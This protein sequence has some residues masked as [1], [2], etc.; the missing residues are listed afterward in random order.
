MTEAT[1]S[2]VSFKSR[3]KKK[4]SLRNTMTSK[5]DD[6]DNDDNNNVDI[7]TQVL[8]IEQQMRKRKMGIDP[9]DA[10][11]HHKHSENIKSEVH[12][13]FKSN[14]DSN[15][16]LADGVVHEK[17]MEQYVEEKL[18]LKSLNN[19]LNGVKGNIEDELYRV[20]DVLKS[21]LSSSTK[22]I[23]KMADS[24]GLNSIAEVNLPST[25]KIRNMQE[26]EAAKKSIGLNSFT[27]NKYKTLSHSRFEN[28]YDSTVV[29]LDLNA[30]K[31]EYQG[32]TIN[33]ITDFAVRDEDNITFDV[34]SSEV[35][36]SSFGTSQ[37]R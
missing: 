1:S 26:V 27:T 14:L 25:Y 12:K 35:T 6:N 21:S 3:N 33:T 20:P 16:S 4:L 19:N 5:N 15:I 13:Q 30:M 29:D 23:D 36:I 11:K 24:I 37:I 7:N 8:K 28:Q 9:I 18:G 22:I 10:I 17:L 32:S 34:E 31:K 2:I